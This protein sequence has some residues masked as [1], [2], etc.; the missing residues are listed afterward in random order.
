MLYDRVSEAIR[1]AKST[2]VST[3]NIAMVDL[4]WRIGGYIVEEE[5][6]GENRAQYG[7]KIIKGL[8]NRL[9]K[10]I[11]RGFLV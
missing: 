5:Q 8:A 10:E 6:N 7:Q 1:N 3:V 4:N 11:G 9:Q 2:V